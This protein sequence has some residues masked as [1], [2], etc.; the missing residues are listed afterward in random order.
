VLA[1]HW[2]CAG[3]TAANDIA[4]IAAPSRP[5]DPNRQRMT[6]AS[7]IYCRR[8]SPYRRY[9]HRLAIGSVSSVSWWLNLFLIWIMN[10]KALYGRAASKSGTLRR[11]ALWRLTVAIE[12][13]AD[14]GLHRRWMA[15]SRMTHHVI[16]PAI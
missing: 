3:T 10:V 14:I 11:I 15:P 7:K 1:G 9:T 2:A 6:L 5:F 13:I 12:G 16:C 8:V 4:N